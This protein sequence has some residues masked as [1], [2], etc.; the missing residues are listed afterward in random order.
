MNTNQ[1]RPKKGSCY[2]KV[3]IRKRNV[4]TNCR[5]SLLQCK[6]WPTETVQ[7]TFLSSFFVKINNVYGEVELCCQ[8][9]CDLPH[10]MHELK[11]EANFPIDRDILI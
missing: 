3:L 7:N 1:F 9:M 10:N 11:K 6:S 8:I 2:F 4:Y 5:A